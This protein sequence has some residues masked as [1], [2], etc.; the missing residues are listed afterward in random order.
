LG[1]EVLFFWGLVLG[2]TEV[3]AVNYYLLAELQKEADFEA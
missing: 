2:R 3:E 1:R